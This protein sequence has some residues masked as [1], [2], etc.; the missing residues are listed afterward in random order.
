VKTVFQ[1][2]FSKKFQLG[3]NRITFSFLILA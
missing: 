3:W 1:S 2:V